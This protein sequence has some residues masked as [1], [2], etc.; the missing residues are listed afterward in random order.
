MKI[1]ENFSYAEVACNGTNCCDNSTPISIP[2]VW[3]AQVLRDKCSEHLGRACP[4]SVNSGYRCNR[5]NQ[6]LIERGYPASPRS[7]HRLGLALDLGLPRGLSI[8]K[9]HKI[10]KTCGFSRILKY[11]WG[12]HVE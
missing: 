7:N 3:K 11:S 1:T 4:I 2:L 9:F 12:L 8:C 5:Y 6:E 10:A